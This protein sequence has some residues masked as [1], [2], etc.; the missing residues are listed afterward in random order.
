MMQRN[1]WMQPDYLAGFREARSQ[2][3]SGDIY[4]VPEALVLFDIDPP[5][6]EFATGMRDGLIAINSGRLGTL[7]KR[8][9]TVANVIPIRSGVDHD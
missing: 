3:M 1:V 4:N 5:H 7:P 9:D 8:S 2:V 6:N